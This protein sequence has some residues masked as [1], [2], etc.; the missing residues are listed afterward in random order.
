[1][2]KRRK[3]GVLG[4]LNRIAAYK[5][6]RAGITSPLGLKASVEIDRKLLW[7]WRMVNSSES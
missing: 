6:A 5:K 7:R 2:K 3:T 1:M 4:V